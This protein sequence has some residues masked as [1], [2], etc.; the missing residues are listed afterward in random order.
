MGLPSDE[1]EH[2]GSVE[3]RQAESRR[4]RIHVRLSSLPCVDSNKQH[5]CAPMRV[6]GSSTAVS[7][8]HLYTLGANAE[9]HRIVP[10][11]YHY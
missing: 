10:K 5:H 1:A 7:H 3:E 6:T 11:N 9:A 8:T 4:A 2:R